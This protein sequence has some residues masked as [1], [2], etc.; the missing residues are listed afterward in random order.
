MLPNEPLCFPVHVIPEEDEDRREAAQRDAET[1]RTFHRRN[2]PNT[3]ELHGE[4]PQL[5][6]DTEEDDDDFE[7]PTPF[8]FNVDDL[9]I[10]AEEQIHVQDK[11]HS[12]EPTMELLHWHYRL[13]HLPF[14]NLQE[15]A[16]RKLL[17]SSLSK[18][19][20]PTCAACLYGKATKRAWR[21]K[22]KPGNIS[23][24]VITGPGC[25]VSVDQLES[26]T[27]GLIAQLRGFIMRQ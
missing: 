6:Q 3:R 13:G 24:A 22:S 19:K 12:L 5:E 26:S 8:D 10:V 14:K 7:E 1:H 11:T 25:C 2:H 23:P 27:T 16:K 15:M 9:N 17:P 18:C 20:V 21:S 4:M